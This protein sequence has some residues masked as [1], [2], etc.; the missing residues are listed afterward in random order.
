MESTE[1]TQWGALLGLNI[2]YQSTHFIVIN[3]YFTSNLQCIFVRIDVAVLCARIVGFCAFSFSSVFPIFCGIYIFL[4]LVAAATVSFYCTLALFT[5]TF[6]LRLLWL[7][8]YTAF[9]DTLRATSFGLFMASIHFHS[10]THF[11]SPSPFA[12][13]KTVDFAVL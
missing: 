8:A 2:Q 1:T 11:P 12:V 3:I 9:I 5:L 10:R 6:R 7:A 4:F 13:L